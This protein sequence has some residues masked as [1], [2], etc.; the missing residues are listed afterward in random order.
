M[1]TH[2]PDPH[3]DR[4]LLDAFDEPIAVRADDGRILEVNLAFVRTLA[5]AGAS[6]DDVLDDRRREE[7]VDD[8]VRGRLDA[9][10]PG[11][12]LRLRDVAV[13]RAGENDHRRVDLVARP[14]EGAAATLVRFAP[15]DAA[16]HAAAITERD[17]RRA[18]VGALAAGIA[19]DVNNH[20]SASM[21]MAILLQEELGESSAHH[22]AL[23]ILVG[24]SKDAAKLSQSLL[25]L[26]VR[27][28]PD[29][30]EVA[31]GPLVE[32][33]LDLLRHDLPPEERLSLEMADDAS[34][35]VGD[36]ARLEHLIA[37]LALPCADA[38]GDDGTLE[39]AVEPDGNETALRFTVRSE[40]SPDDPAALAL[41]ESLV[42]DHGGT[43]DVTRAP[44][45]TTFR[46]RLR[47]WT[48]TS[49]SV[50]ERSSERR[51]LVVDREESVR[52]VTVAMIRRLGYDAIGVTDGREALARIERDP[53]VALLF[54]DLGL[55]ADRVDEF[56]RDA[57][58]LGP[59]LAVIATPGVSPAERGVITPDHGIDELLEKPYTLATLR[60]ALESRLG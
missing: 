4:A 10:R 38:A 5:A 51:V 7:I 19:H 29:L 26:V 6:R 60:N 52:D 27:A 31:L 55:L 11:V 32:E 24:A 50:A 36:P 2:R 17:S 20:L 9:V 41:A 49:A 56:L 15:R 14:L 21:N 43:L 42:A 57:R 22:E 30:T 40:T 44:G 3:P 1:T 13:W 53:G 47:P 12:S 16:S 48:T 8:S 23:E 54:V 33:I 35:I 37:L 34:T 45:E 58:A 59:D 39:V 28:E 46:A 18:I 25:R